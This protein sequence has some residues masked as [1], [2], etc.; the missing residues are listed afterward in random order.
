MSCILEE[1]DD[2][3]DDKFKLFVKTLGLGLRLSEAVDLEV[4]DFIFDSNMTSVKIRNGKGGKERLVAV[5][6]H[7]NSFF[8]KLDNR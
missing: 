6:T 5:P 7:L 4:R 2:G 8:K 1:V 3:N